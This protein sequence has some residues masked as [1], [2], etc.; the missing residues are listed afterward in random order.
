MPAG[1]RCSCAANVTHAIVRHY[2][3]LITRPRA[4]S[5]GYAIVRAHRAPRPRTRESSNRMPSPRRDRVIDRSESVA[6]V[7]GQRSLHDSVCA[8][9]NAAGSAGAATALMRDLQDAS[10]HPANWSL[11]QRPWC[12]SV[13]SEGSGPRTT[14]PVRFAAPSGRPSTSPRAG[15]V[16]ARGPS[17]LG[18]A[19]LTGLRFGDSISPSRAERLRRSGRL[20]GW[21]RWKRAR[22]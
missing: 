14:G 2:G 9:P 22:R 16:S 5:S 10:E 15:P 8:E 11:A 20:W 1:L 19:R 17:L 3:D 7:P 12:S 18:R 21:P 6:W 4:R 13:C